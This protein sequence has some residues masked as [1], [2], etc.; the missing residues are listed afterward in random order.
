MTSRAIKKFKSEQQSGLRRCLSCGTL[1][2]MQRRKYCSV[3]CRQR[4]RNQ[5]NM[6]T[7]LLK[8]LQTKCATFYFTDDVIILD[9]LPWGA[10]ELSSFIY[11][12]SNGKKPVD[13]FCTLSNLLGNAWWAERRRTNKRYLAS[14]HVFDFAHGKNGDPDLVKPVHIRQPAKLYNSLTFLKLNRK[15]LESQDLPDIIKSAY[16]RQALKMHPDHGGSASLFRKLQKAYEQ[17][18]NWADNPVYTTRRPSPNSRP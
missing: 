15:D 13:D 17:L 7:G 1:E 3:E 18:V 6:R 9:V 10:A 5:L 14:R 12:R 4:L 16:R 8:A 2:N 11:P